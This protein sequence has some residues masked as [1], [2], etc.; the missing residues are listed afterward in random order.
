M[1]E[2]SSDEAGRYPRFAPDP[3]VPSIAP[4]GGI[5]LRAVLDGLPLEAADD[6]GHGALDGDEFDAEP[7]EPFL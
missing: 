5:G 1:R 7:A 3:Q 4:S 6:S 2:I